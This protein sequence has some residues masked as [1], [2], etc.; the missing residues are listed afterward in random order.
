MIYSKLFS[1]NI[2][3]FREVIGAIAQTN[4][5]KKNPLISRIR[6]YEDFLSLPIITADE[7]NLVPGDLTIDVK[8]CHKIKTSGTTGKYKTIYLPKPLLAD[9]LGKIEDRLIRNSKSVF[10]FA[11]MDFG[12]EPF[13]LAHHNRYKN[14][15][16]NASFKKISGVDSVI[17]ILQ[18]YEAISIFDYPSFFMR[19]I[20]FSY[21]AIKSGQISK[22]ELKVRN[23]HAKLTG[24][25]MHPTKI[26]RWMYE[27]KNTLGCIPIMNLRYGAS[28]V[29]EIGVCNFEIY[30]D[31]ITYHVRNQ[32]SF[33]EVLDP[34]TNLPVLG[35]EG[36]VVVTAFRETGTILLRYFLGDYA[37]AFVKNDQLYIK[38]IYRPGVL[39][40]AGISISLDYITSCFI[41]QFGP[42]IR[43]HAKRLL[44]SVTGVYKFYIKFFIYE[45]CNPTIKNFDLGQYF[46]KLVK[47]SIPIIE[48]LLN[49]RAVI[50]K[51]EKA[52][53]Y[54]KQWGHEK[55]WKYQEVEDESNLV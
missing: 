38:N 32:H 50:F 53:I 21:L 3:R 33:L 12:S 26:K 14:D 19:F 46:V 13:M 20:Y 7:L 6:N 42:G 15:Y 22:E 5:G 37:T 48:E 41:D 10:I 44:S 34:V 49:D 23:V 51:F 29:K 43:I 30:D 18:N 27:C 9:P 31:E 16:P 54:S 11:A 8:S 47:Q 40:I 1:E 35:K 24:E 36:K 25:P 28:E 17:S 45:D 2:D 55:Y 4:Y 39:Y 52:T